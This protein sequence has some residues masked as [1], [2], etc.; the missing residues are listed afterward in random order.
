MTLA[1]GLELLDPV[2]NALLGA[3]ARLPAHW[4]S[5]PDTDF[6]RFALV[7][8]LFLAPA[9]AVVGVYVVNLRMA[10]FSDAI[11]HSAFSGVALG[12][13]LATAGVSGIDPRF[14]LVAFG[15]LVGLL[16]TAVKRRTE[17]GADTVIG[18][19][20]SAVIALGIVIISYSPRFLRDFNHY[21]YG[22]ILLL[23]LADLRTALL[24][25]LV[26]ITFMVFGYNRLLLIGLNEDL[27][28]T[29]GVRA[30]L[31]DYVFAALVVL[32]VTASIRITGLLLVTAMLVVPAAAAR[33]LA[34]SAGQMFWLASAIGL[35]AGA[36]GLIASYYLD[37]AAGATVILAGTLLFAG[38]LAWRSWRN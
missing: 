12:F 31:Y 11:A 2:L 38:S 7:A 15:L 14:T 23:D 36:G 1:L 13:L 6:M 3:V 19:A 9:C 28:R 30:R 33:N 18:V 34:R 24:L 20:F 26:V 25:A 8:L 35:A 22:D 29:R 32:L 27:A 16:I 21:L 4:A 5:S 10:F 17:L 37:T